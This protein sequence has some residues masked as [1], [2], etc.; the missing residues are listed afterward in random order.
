MYVVSPLFFDPVFL[1]A[2][3]AICT[4]YAN[5]FFFS[6]DRTLSGLFLIGCNQ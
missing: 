1:F 5:H 6:W 4:V 2:I 3:I